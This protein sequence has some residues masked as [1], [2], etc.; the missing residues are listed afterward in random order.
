MIR[1]NLFI[2]IGN[3]SFRIIPCNSILLNHTMAMRLVLIA[4]LFI[5]N[6]IRKVIHPNVT[7]K[8]SNVYKKLVYLFIFFA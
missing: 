7:I 5:A 6:D 2:Y 3:K 8:F 4:S 1:A